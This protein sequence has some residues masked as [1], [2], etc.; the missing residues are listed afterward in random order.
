MYV[1]YGSI[2]IIAKTEVRFLDKRF[3]YFPMQG[4]LCTLFD[5]DFDSSYSVTV[6][7]TFASLVDDNELEAKFKTSILKVILKSLMCL[8]NCC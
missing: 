6:N 5:D 8:L 4:I 1:D 3:G 7:K 2:E